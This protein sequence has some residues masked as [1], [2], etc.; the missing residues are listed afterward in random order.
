MAT[1]KACKSWFGSSAPGDLCPTCQR[2]LKRLNGYAVPVV[3][4]R[5]CRRYKTVTWYD[6]EPYGTFC[7]EFKINGGPDFYCAYGQRR[8]EGDG[9]VD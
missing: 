5:E 6:G 8:E 9:D 4:C 1:C 2:A 7:D 3:R